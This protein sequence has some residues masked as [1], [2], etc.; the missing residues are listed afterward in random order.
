MCDNTFH[1]N[2]KDRP[3]TNFLFVWFVQLI[4]WYWFQRFKFT[5]NCSFSQT[6][7]FSSK[8]SVFYQ[9]HFHQT[10]SSVQ[11]STKCI[12]WLIDCLK[13]YL[14]IRVCRIVDDCKTWK[15][16]FFPIVAVGC[17]KVYVCLTSG[18]TISVCFH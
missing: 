14:L 12:F 13:C 4:I 11:N 5:K 18:M 10:F 6:Y 1:R 16:L 8:V 7:P 17:D 3:A 2:R 9:R 15:D